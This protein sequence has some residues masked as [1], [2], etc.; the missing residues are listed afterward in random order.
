MKKIL[1]INSVVNYGSTGRIVED[2]GKLS[3][4]DGWDSYIAFGRKRK[5]ISE[6]N[7]I[8]VGN[9]YNTISHIL[10]TRLFDRHGFGSRRATEKLIE[11]IIRI[12]PDI[13]HLHNIHGYYIN[14]PVLF[15]YLKRSSKPVVWTLHDCW[16]F[17]GH[18]AYFDFIGCSKWKEECNNCPQIN[19]YPSSF[20]CD[21]SR[22][23][24]YD[25]EKFVS[26][27]DNLTIITVS[28]WLSE[29]VQQSLLKKFNAKI[30]NNGVD[31]KTFRPIPESTI[32]EKYELDNK[33][34]ILGVANDWSARKGYA[35][36]IKLNSY[37]DNRYKIVLVGLS[38]RQIR[39]LPNNI[40]G[41]ERLKSAHE[42]AQLYSRCDVFVNPTWED[43]FPT[44]NIES[45]AC[46]TPV[47]TYNT[48]GSPEAINQSTG[49]IVEKGNVQDL[50]S[51]VKKI[52]DYGKYK[53]INKCVNHVSKNYNS[54]RQYSK[55]V[56]IYNNILVKNSEN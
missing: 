52:C 39:S 3:I 55:Y 7:T 42:L 33:F 31:Q 9:Y 46:G 30:I 26:A 40:I 4:K 48:G 2:I 11:N 51:A 6:S 18:C 10:L 37:I 25:K 27:I 13:I 34:L 23:N 49:I 24:F 15:N 12:D 22:M 41:I 17:T 32:M 50:W 29:L 38:K 53:Y 54:K 1:Q 44:T 14:I 8:I 43:N 35:D 45:L 16:S 5:N 20:M 56:E 47:V 36:F 21:R 28:R 19:S